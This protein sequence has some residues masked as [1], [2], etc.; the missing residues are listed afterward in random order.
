MR[1][2]KIEIIK[3]VAFDGKVITNGEIYGKVIYPAK[4]VDLKTFYEI[5]DEEYAEI[6]KKQEEQ[7]EQE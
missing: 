3:L 7:G 2:E 5:T 6:V 1:T 4:D